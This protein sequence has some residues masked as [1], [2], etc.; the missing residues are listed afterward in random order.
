MN[1]NDYKN[2]IRFLINLITLFEREDILRYIYIVLAD[3]AATIPAIGERDYDNIN[4]EL[5]EDKRE[6][7]INNKMKENEDRIEDMFSDY[8]EQLEENGFLSCEIASAV[9]KEKER[10]RD[11]AICMYEAEYD[12]YVEDKIKEALQG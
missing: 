5:L 4:R 8:R 6:E 1:A 7:Y 2:K 12:S 3:I 9:E 11:E 10:L